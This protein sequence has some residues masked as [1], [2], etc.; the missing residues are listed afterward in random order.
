VVWKLMLAVVLGIVLL[1]V[2]EGLR[3]KHTPRMDFRAGFWVLPWLGGL[4]LISWLGRYPELDKHAGNV[5]LLGMGSGLIV[6]VIFSALVMWLA[7][8]FRLRGQRVVDHVNESWGDD[9]I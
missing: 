3:G 7:H 1:G 8:A 2:H 6:I 9:V 5:G 4:A